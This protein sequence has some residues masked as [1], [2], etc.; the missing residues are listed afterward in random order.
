ME[1]ENFNDVSTH[2]YTTIEQDR[3]IPL[4]DQINSKY[5]YGLYTWIKFIAV[6]LIL[7]LEGIHLTF[8]GTLYIPIKSYYNL[9]D[10]EMQFY[11][12]IIFPALGV[13]SLCSGY[14]TEKISRRNLLLILMITIAFSHLGIGVFKNLIM[15][16]V[17]RII[18]GFSLG[19]TSLITL[20]IFAEYLPINYRAIIL[21]LVW[22]GFSFGNIVMLVL[23]LFIMP[24]LE[25]SDF[26]KTILYSS[27]YSFLPL[28]ITFL[29]LKDSPRNLILTGQTEA[30]FEILNRLNGEELTEDKKN[31]IIVESKSGLNHDLGIRFKDIFNSELYKT[32]ILLIFIIMINSL[33]NYGPFLIVTPTMKDI[34]IK[35]EQMNNNE[36]IYNQIYIAALGNL[37][38]ILGGF[39]CEVSWL[40]RK[41]AN[42]V[43]S[44]LAL[45]CIIL[46]FTIKDMFG[47][48]FGFY[49]AFAGISF[50]ITSTYSAEIYPTRVRDLALGFLFSMTR[51][52]GF[53]SQILYITFHNAGT[54]VPFYITSG[55]LVIYI[56]LVFFLPIETYKRPLDSHISNEDSVSD[57]E[58]LLKEN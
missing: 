9:T 32:T 5:G 37:G 39:M 52:G 51:I 45:T 15:F 6:F 57:K 35:E 2:D 29:F 10:N 47:L 27:I 13:G 36:I 7:S 44:I 40:G 25:T 18:I 12:S 31:K 48:I 23:M 41:K 8:F 19:M 50:N 3:K 43:A 22:I 17:F 34:G 46:L 20:N 33:V 16:T 21:I 28:I 26:Q 38:N 11:S 53:V 54:W 1:N 55:V 4:I 58:R 24:N 42:M 14:F 56:V 30:G 49:G